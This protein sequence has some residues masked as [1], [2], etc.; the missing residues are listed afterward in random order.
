[1]AL[2]TFKG[3]IH[4]NDGKD[5]AKD[6]PIKEYL[7][8]G[9]CVFPVSQHIGAPAKPIVKK[10]DRVLVGQKIA[11][12]GGFVSA[13]IFSSISGTV[14][15][16]EPHLTPAGAMVNSIVV[17]ND[18]LFE[19]VE[20]SAKP[21]EEMSREEVIGAI[22]EAGVIGLGGAGFPTHVKLSPKNADDIEYII[23]NAAECEPYITADYRCMLETPEVMI[24]GLKIIL[25]LFPKAK[26]I[27]GVE[28]NKPDA[29]KKLEGLTSS[30]SR[31]QVAPLKTKYPQGA[32][33]SLIFATT[34]R[35][36]NSSMLP[37]DAG[38]IVDNVATAMAIHDAVKEGKP[39]YERVVTVSGDAVNQPGNFLVHAGTN[40]QELVEAA[41][42]FK[43]QPE[44]VISGGPMM[45]MAMYNLDVPAV[46]A[47]SSLLAFKEDEVSKSEPSNCI[48]CGRCVSV[49]PAKLMPT[50][51]AA[52]ADHHEIDLFEQ[53]DGAECVECGSCSYICPAKRPLTQSMKAG[54]RQVLANRR[55]K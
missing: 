50:K 41:G 44:K 24:S 15:K 37:A 11:E 54:R 32:E 47:F 16:I 13:N 1:M 2:F 49:C 27:I 12:A 46:K 25:D 4:P 23:I 6:Q 29:I 33:R 51:L 52:Y 10:G 39:L 28:D 55:K 31:I 20:F 9:D 3:G 19:S 18:G 14:K 22:K 30:E 53:H 5:L 45:G 43:S 40:L 21:Y 42:G 36:I 17:E 26:G 48:R 34:G 8:K 38:C 7:P 35:E